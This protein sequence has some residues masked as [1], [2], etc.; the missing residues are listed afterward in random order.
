M[1]MFPAGEHHA[2]PDSTP[3]D[4]MSNTSTHRPFS[5]LLRRRAAHGVTRSDGFDDAPPT[6]DPRQ[7]PSD[8]ASTGAGQLRRGRADRDLVA[9]IER[10]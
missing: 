2:P 4:Q 5:P 7:G 9:A 8:A 3:P 1:V 6:G 10:G